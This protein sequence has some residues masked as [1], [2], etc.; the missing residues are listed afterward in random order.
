[1]EVVCRLAQLDITAPEMISRHSAALVIIQTQVQ[2]LA[3]LVLMERGPI[4]SNAMRRSFVP[5]S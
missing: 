1:M 3:P 4:V 2:R 5:L